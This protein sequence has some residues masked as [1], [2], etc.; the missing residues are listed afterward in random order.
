MPRQGPFKSQ[1]GSVAVA[2][3]DRTSPCRGAFTTWVPRFL[4]FN[5][6]KK[7]PTH[8]QFHVAP[9]R[10]LGRMA[11]KITKLGCGQSQVITAPSRTPI[12]A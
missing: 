6:T 11:E 4:L 7:R 3:P 9:A 2:L 10:R 1:R 8:G 12:P 5:P